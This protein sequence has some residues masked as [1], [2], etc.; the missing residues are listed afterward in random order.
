MAFL[1]VRFR[2][3]RRREKQGLGESCCDL[4]NVRGKVVISTF[5]YNGLA[6][7]TKNGG[8]I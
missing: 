2:E 6:N 1:L 3:R 4:V 8:I 5:S 7:P